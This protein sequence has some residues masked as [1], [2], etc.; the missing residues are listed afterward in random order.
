MSGQGADSRARFFAL[1]DDVFGALAADEVAFCD[2]SAERSDFVRLSGGRVRQAGSV[3]QEQLTL[4]LAHGKR[5]A[6]ATLSLS[7]DREGDAARAA[8]LLPE[9]RAL[10]AQLPEDPYFCFPSAPLEHEREQPASLPTRE[11]ALAALEA[12]SAAHDLVGIYAAGPQLRGHASSAGRRLFSTS[13]SFNVDFSLHLDGARAVKGRYAGSDFS[14][15]ALSSRVSDAAAQLDVLARAPRRVEPGRYRVYLAPAAVAE[16]LALLCWGGFGLKSWRTQQ[17]PLRR[18]V[19]GERALDARVS[20]AELGV[21]VPSPAFDAAGFVKPERVALVEGGRAGTPLVSARSSAEY[22]VAA[23]GCGESESPAALEMAGGALEMAHAVRDVGEGLYVG[24]LWYLNYSD[25]GS[26]R[27]TGMTRFATL[28]VEGGELVAPVSAMRF[29]ESF[30][31][32]LGHK[33]VGITRERELLLDP[34][35]YGQRSTDSMRVPGVIVDDF[36]LTL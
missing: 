1:A 5:H 9:L 30:Y 35:S 3:A 24:N 28:W 2:L 19:A 11:Q 27:I 15:A 36:T 7:S 14:A 26:C 16:L 17:T 8:A 25:R 18:L 10:V 32:A 4:R 13:A 31:D 6:A 33:L 29:D 23:N 20:L 12:A 34:D 21:G 22:G